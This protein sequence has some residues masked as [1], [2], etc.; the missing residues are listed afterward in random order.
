MSKCM[1]RLFIALTL[2]V[3]AAKS[4]VWGQKLAS[5]RTHPKQ[6][7]QLFRT[8]AKRI[9]P[10]L[11]VIETLNGPRELGRWAERESHRFQRATR[12]ALCINEPVQPAARDSF[13]SGVI[14]DKR[15]YVV[16]CNHVVAGAEA[17]FIKLSD[18]R[19]R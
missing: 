3:S 1:N 17:A 14:I 19:L 7:P 10:S 9:Q 5:T 13:G 18:V 11:V 8:A 16:T 15:R 4:P 2:L 6:M 12:V